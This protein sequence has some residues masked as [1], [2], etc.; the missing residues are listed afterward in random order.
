MGYCHTE[1][2]RYRNCFKQT[3]EIFVISPLIVKTPNLPRHRDNGDWFGRMAQ[4]ELMPESQARQAMIRQNTVTLNID[5]A[6]LN[7]LKRRLSQAVIEKTL[8]ETEN[9]LSKA[10]RRL[11]ISRPTLYNLISRYGLSRD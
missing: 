11:G 7:E 9:N 6:D 3:P 10:A 8:R 4:K 5:G 1:T 2:V